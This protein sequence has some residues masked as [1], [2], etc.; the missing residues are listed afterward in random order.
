VYDKGRG[1]RGDERSGGGGSKG[2][3]EPREVEERRRPVAT[4]ERWRVRM[5]WRGGARGCRG[6]GCGPRWE[7]RDL[8]WVGIWGLLCETL[9]YFGRRISRS[10]NHSDERLIWR[11]SLKKW[12]TFLIQWNFS[13]LTLYI[14]II[15]WFQKITK[16]LHNNTYIAYCVYKKI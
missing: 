16:K 9:I 3:E 1:G 7:G 2:G 8:G 10:T 13:N 5:Q 11:V 12:Q 4:G 15:N 6:G 14:K